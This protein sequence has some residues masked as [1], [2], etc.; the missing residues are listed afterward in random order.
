MKKIMVG[1]L[2]STYFLCGTSLH[3][4]AESETPP[5]PILI[6]PI[7][8]LDTKGSLNSNE[9]NVPQ[10]KLGP[11]KRLSLPD[12]LDPRGTN[13]EIPVRKQVGGL[14]WAYSSTDI[15]TANYKKQTG[16][17]QILSPNF[18]NFY[19]A[20]NA[21]SDGFNPNTII[22]NK[23]KDAI[24][25]RKLNNGGFHNYPLFQNILGNRGTAEIDFAMPNVVSQNQPLLKEKFDAL[26]E[27][28]TD[29]AINEIK[30]IP[31]NSY[32]IA[33]SERKLKIEKIKQF[34]QE[35]GAVTYNYNSETIS[36]SSFKKYYNNTTKASYVPNADFN[37]IPNYPAFGRPN[38]DHTVTIVGWDNTFSKT[39]FAIQPEQDG[40]FIVKNSWGTS[41][42]DQG[43]FY[44]SY[45]DI[46]VTTGAFYSVTT[47][48]PT[49][50]IRGYV[51]STSDAWG[52]VEQIENNNNKIYLAANF[53]TKN[54][55]ELLK[56][57]AFLT[58]QN[59]INYKIYYLNRKL[60][61]E[62]FNSAIFTDLIAEGKQE[63]AGMR[64][65]PTKERTLPANESYSIIIELTYPDDLDLQNFTAQ[66]VKKEDQEDRAPVLQAGDTLVSLNNNRWRNTSKGEYWIKNYNL[67]IT[68]GTDDSPNEENTVSSIIIND[69]I[70]PKL[71][72]Q[73]KPLQLDTTI[74]PESVKKKELVWSSNDPEIAEV[75][76]FGT[77]T[78]KAHGRTT[79]RVSSKQNP[80]IFDE[81]S[82]ITDDHGCTT[83]TSTR[84]TIGEPMVG[85]ID[86]DRDEYVPEN[87]W[88]NRG[89]VFTYLIP[90]DGSY[91]VHGY[92]MKPDQ[93]QDLIGTDFMTNGKS[94]YIA[95][96]NQ[97]FTQQL[98]KGDL[99]EI[100]VFPSMLGMNNPLGDWNKTT[101]GTSYSI[102]FDK[103]SNFDYGK[104]TWANSGG[105]TK[106]SLKNTFKIGEKDQFKGSVIDSNIQDPFYTSNNSFYFASTWK[107]S[108][109][110]VA[111]INEK[112]GELEALSSGETVLYNTYNLHWWSKIE[113]SITITV[114]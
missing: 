81:L 95:V 8:S 53:Q 61:S 64:N 16:T 43:Y 72:Y 59:N 17:E 83:E 58:V 13:Q 84:L 73:N 10:S 74:M 96:A 30:Q 92:G 98:K 51:N 100:S 31:F 75:D 1:L 54:T 18:Y 63:E 27:N 79:I 46:F 104:L 97:F 103:T 19:S 107:S 66:A 33:D 47:A 106:E 99:V 9:P 35:S 49:D 36:H 57:V 108:K 45:D 101:V 37:K 22:L 93:T 60:E 70:E 112:T 28:K 4:F 44:V 105:E 90:E 80:D 109:P 48:E 102:S 87:A 2:L 56:T 41:S 88:Y 23:T 39:N 20:E 85:M 7:D 34:I 77:V 32:K 65:I 26:E 24:T 114:E 42:G 89:D 15:I 68:A 94:R 71:V 29:V 40:A 110:K 12:K 82:I 25:N 62:S 55:E 50:H 52:E 78:A 91:T 6:A 69:K 5:E 3:V 76:Q 14:C 11:K 113:D 38:I 86:I 67:Y 21:F 111:T